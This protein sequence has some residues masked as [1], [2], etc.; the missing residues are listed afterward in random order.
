MHLY[1]YNL[2]ARVVDQY[3]AN[4]F[5][6]AGAVLADADVVAR[7]K[8]LGVNI[9]SQLGKSFDEAEYL[10]LQQPGCCPNCHLSTIELLRGPHNAVQCTTCGT[11]GQLVVQSDGRILPE[12]EAGSIWSCQTSAGK[13]KHWED[14]TT[15]LEREATRLSGIQEEKKRWQILD[16]N[17]IALPSDELEI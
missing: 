14:I 13:T 6:N 10:G 1:F 16:L 2:H 12:W 11:T 3:V 7:T 8:Q 9:A 15:G 4:G 5:S 17:R